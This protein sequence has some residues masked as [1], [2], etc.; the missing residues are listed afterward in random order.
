MSATRTAQSGT[1]ETAAPGA[2]VKAAKAAPAEAVTA[3]ATTAKTAAPKATTAKTATAK[4]TTPKAATTKT[5]TAK[6]PAAKATTART[7][8]GES[9]P[10]PAPV[11]AETRHALIREAAYFRAER[12]G[13]AEG[14]PEADWA[15][16]EAEIDQLLA[17]AADPAP[18]ARKPARKR[19]SAAQ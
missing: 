5:A 1:P 8:P 16:A 15:A 9:R 17:A 2:A 4:T 13:F 3:K 11:S 19:T 18:A 7:A 14:D 10:E 6:T 12:R